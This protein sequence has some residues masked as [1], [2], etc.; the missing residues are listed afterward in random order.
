[1]RFSAGTKSCRRH[2]RGLGAA[3]EAPA[4]FAEA[5]DSIHNDEEIGRRYRAVRAHRPTGCQL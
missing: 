1:M 2:T 4:D 3:V 5:A